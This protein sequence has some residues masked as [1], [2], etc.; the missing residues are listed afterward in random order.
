MLMVVAVVSIAMRARIR[1]HY[2]PIKSGDILGIYI[3]GVLGPASGTPSP[4]WPDGFPVPVQEDGTVGLPR[5][6]DVRVAGL[7]PRTARER[8][9]DAYLS[10]DIVGGNAAILVT[11]LREAP[12]P[13]PYFTKAEFTQ[14][15]DGNQ[16]GFVDGEEWDVAER[17]L[18]AA[19]AD[20]DGHISHAEA[21]GIFPRR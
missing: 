6:G 5:I 15:Y 19:D 14:R 10:Q 21:K 18:S 4:D 12:V 2:R 11:M 16:N 9:L 8:I 17:E 20:S 7:T 1:R 13:E 3:D